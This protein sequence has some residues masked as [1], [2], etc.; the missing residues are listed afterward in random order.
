MHESSYLDFDLSME[1]GQ[2]EDDAANGVYGVRVLNSPAGEPRGAFK[3]PFGGAQLKSFFQMVSCGGESGG[4]A[5]V[6]FG[7]QLFSALFEGKVRD[8]LVR[9]LDAAERQG[10][11][12]RIRL[13]LN[14][15]PELATLPW[16]YLRDPVGQNFLVL[17][18]Q[19]PIVRYLELSATEQPLELVRPLRILMVIA[20]PLD[21]SPLDAEDEWQKVQKALEALQH[22]GL[23]EIHRLASGTLAEL[24]NQLRKDEYHILHFIGHGIPSSPNV[25][26]GKM[27]AAGGRR[28]GLAFVD[29]KGFSD[30]V[31]A[32]KLATLL[33]DHRSLRLVLL[34]ACDA[35]RAAVDNPFAGTAQRLVQQGLP[36]VIAM[37]SAVSDEAAITLTH[38]FY[39]ALAIGRPVDAALA[40]ARKAIFTRVNKLEWATPVLFMRAPD[41]KLFEIEGVG[42]DAPAPGVPPFKGLYYFEQKDADRFFG[43][44]KLTAQLVARLRPPADPLSGADSSAEGRFLA[45]IGASGSGKSSLVRAGVL[46]ALKEGNRLNDSHGVLPPEGSE[47][48]PVHII[49]PTAHP[50]ESLAVSLTA[51]SESVTAA[52]TLIN[53]LKETPRA[54]HLYVRR[55]LSQQYNSTGQAHNGQAQNGRKPSL[56]AIAA[57]AAL[58]ASQNRLLRAL[59][60]ASALG[61]HQHQDNGAIPN[62]SPRW[63]AHAQPPTLVP[64]PVEGRQAQD[65]AFGQSSRRLLLVVDQFEELFTLCHSAQERQAF[66]DNLMHAVTRNGPT[67]VVIALRADFYAHC[68]QFEPLREIL[69]KQQEFIGPMNEDE[70]RRAIEEPAGQGNWQFEPGLVDQ[71]L[72]DVGSEPGAL[73]LLSHA[74]LETWKRRRGRMLTFAGYAASGGIK[75]AIAKT[76]ERVFNLGLTN[77]QQD[78]AR[79]IFLQLTELGEGTQDT[80]RRVALEELV[81][82]SHSQIAVQGVLETLSHARLV[83]LSSQNAEVAHEALIRNWPT[84]HAWLDEDREGLRI[85]RQLN[86]DAEEWEALDRDAGALYRGA[87]LA[88][89]AEWGARHMNQMN[90]LERRFLGASKEL[91]E[92]EDLEEEERQRKELAQ[93]QALAEE[94]ARGRERLAYFSK[95]LSG[96]LLVAILATALAIFQARI[97]DQ[98]TEEAREAEAAAEAE[99]ET[100]Q[101]NEQKAREAEATADAERKEAERQS[102]I[103]LAKSLTGQVPY[104]LNTT[105]NSGLASLLS[106]EA[107]YLNEQLEGG[108]QELIGFSLL[109]VL[110][111]PYFNVILGNHWAAIR[112]VAFSPDGNML[113]SATEAG[114]LHFWDLS[115]PDLDVQSVSGHPKG[116]TVAAFASDGTL[117]SGGAD[118]RIRLWDLTGSEP[119]SEA[120]EVL[121]DDLGPIKSL[122]FSPPSTPPL[123]AAAGDASTIQIWDLNPKKLHFVLPNHEATVNSVAFSSDGKMLA[124]GDAKGKIYLWDLASPPAASV[125]PQ[126]A[127]N[128]TNGMPNGTLQPA[129]QVITPT[130][131]LPQ[132]ASDV[133]SLAFSP[134]GRWLATASEESIILIYDLSDLN[135]DPIELNGHTR[136]VASLEFNSDGTK[137]ASASWDLTG[138]LWDLS[139]GPAQATSDALRGHA[140]YV[141]AVAFSPDGEQLAS[142]SLDWVVR[143]WNLPKG[144]Q[145]GSSK[146]TSA[147]PI[148]L[149]HD[150]QKVWSVAFSAD[151]KHMASG[152]DDGQVRLWPSEVISN[153]TLE[154]T[155]LLG[156]QEWVES[157]AFHPD[158]QMLA[159]ASGDKTI[160]LWDINHPTTP[161]ATLTGHE[162]GI[163]S[164]AFSP[165]GNTLASGSYDNRIRLWDITNITNLQAESTVLARQE[166]LVLSVAFSADGKT[167]ASANE[168]GVIYTESTV[169]ARQEKLVLSVAFSPDG[170][171]LASAS[172]DGAIYLW[173]LSQ[174]HLAPNVLKGH[175]LFVQSVAFSPDGNWLASGSGDSRV[176]LWDLTSDDPS[177]DSIVFKGHANQVDFVAFSP[178]GKS[179]VSAAGDKTIRLWNPAKPDAKPFVFIGHTDWVRSLAFTPDGETLA[180]S[181]DDGTVRLWIARI[182]RLTDLGCQLVRRNLSWT[183]WKDY[184]EDEPY[185]LTCPQLRLPWSAID[186]LIKEAKELARNGDIEAAS[187]ELQKMLELQPEPEW[188]LRLD[189]NFKSDPEA[190]AKRYA[191]AYQLATE[192]E[193]LLKEGEIEAAKAKF[194]QAIK[195]DLALP[196]HLETDVALL[197]VAAGQEVAQAGKVDEALAKFKHAQK[198]DPDVDIPA[199]AWH[200]LCEFGTQPQYAQKVLPACDEAI[201]LDPTNSEYYKTRSLVRELTGD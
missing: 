150:Q 63:L 173:D 54:L 156:H 89:A 118:G 13:R 191:E 179:L 67:V 101:E 181:S 51:Y 192:G 145:A 162:E 11:G 157:V 139:K 111:Q 44:E 27:G 141:Y 123:L 9:S 28:G 8:C 96:L 98:K 131:E 120:S 132:Q 128:A 130:H 189:S 147:A 4:L 55:V 58:P 151:G 152:S 110:S 57:H 135:A 40:E 194:N 158:G 197:W 161:I 164:V 48:W 126:S 121:A 183:E 99:R 149:D 56:G 117:A 154:P 119:T 133:L 115:R 21:L 93:A 193:R 174:P 35:G 129:S 69:A 76:A 195:L 108:G 140:D 127:Q 122:A 109:D 34:N 75:G 10:K 186:G 171:T 22:R 38:E 103:S 7:E 30:L 36:S 142:G 12:L 65:T 86:E 187:D 6:N 68:A 190:D 201:E 66:V 43:R 53:D 100:A 116:I 32:S 106:M 176:R 26:G 20:N 178:D 104:I 169:L 81:P 159:S 160:R 62:G 94:Q 80:R 60:P 59:L 114:N 31:S 143:L 92:R 107:R 144:D 125:T 77:E 78:I 138:R 184:L 83:T 85:H 72:K 163:R 148:S 1:R 165:D 49:T 29:E 95:W 18:D 19:T 146:M 17:S 105:N 2:R 23:V 82:N 200:T 61:H 73:P 90:R 46:P 45:V 134:D 87:R 71:L 155:L 185:R 88:Q 170:K 97:S 14:D 166:E 91:A 24:Q 198:L 124:S 172:E 5:A 199:D 177:K 79:Q 188:L 50:L 175:N 39:Q 16:E 167:L 37:Q 64:E 47:L 33:H 15:V 84:L 180:S 3:L 112:S 153:P 41:G 102:R 137:L 113:V 52:D 70:L 74:L 136:G 168:D 25:R 182:D 196:D 42:E